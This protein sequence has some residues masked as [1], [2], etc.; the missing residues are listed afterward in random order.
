MIEQTTCGEKEDHDRGEK[1]G[2]RHQSDC[3]VADVDKIARVYAQ[4]GLDRKKRDGIDKRREGRVVGIK[5]NSP[6]HHLAMRP[7]LSNRARSNEIAVPRVARCGIASDLG[8][9]HCLRRG[10]PAKIVHIDSGDCDYAYNQKCPPEPESEIASFDGV[11]A[12]LD[13]LFRATPHFAAPRLGHSRRHCFPISL[14][15]SR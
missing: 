10:Q 9:V 11:H 5:P 7:K 6:W 3:F 8:L 1:K 2:D 14:R 13:E 4:A 12:S 15:S